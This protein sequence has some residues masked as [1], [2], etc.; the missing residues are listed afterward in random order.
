MPGV[1]TRLRGRGESPGEDVLRGVSVG[2][3]PVAARDTAE[4][5]L[6]IAVLRGRA[7]VRL[8]LVP[9]VMEL[10]GRANW[11]LPAWLARLLPAG[12]ADSVSADE[13]AAH[14]AEVR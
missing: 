11:W 13:P 4:Y 7:V 2:V 9:A 10:L 6:A 12:R 8:V 5:R 14:P 1:W 3:V